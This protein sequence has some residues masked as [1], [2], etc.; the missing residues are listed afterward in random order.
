[1]IHTSSKFQIILNYCPKVMACRNL[2]PLN[3]WP[4]IFTISNLHNFCYTTPNSTCEYNLESSWHKEQSPKISIKKDP[5]SM[6]YSQP[7]FGLKPFQTHRTHSHKLKTLRNLFLTF[8]TS[9]E[10]GHI[11]PCHPT[12]S[13]PQ[14][15]SLLSYPFPF[16]PHKIP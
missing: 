5:C 2:C 15:T 6:S 16:L 14:G 11:S 4:R 9:S 8:F 1:M 12:Q 7:S 3:G 10:R 13:T